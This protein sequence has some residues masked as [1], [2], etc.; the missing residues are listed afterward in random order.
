MQELI[1]F[2]VDHGKAV[3]FA[4]AFCEQL[5]L[6]VP[7]T[8]FFVGAGVMAGNG[9]GS[10]VGSYVLS[11]A[12]S[13]AGDC[14]WFFLGRYKGRD[15]LKWVCK[16]SLEP[17][18]CVRDTEERFAAHRHSSLIWARFLPIAGIAVRPLA[19]ITGMSLIRFLFFDGIGNVLYIAAAIGAGYFFSDDVERY[20]RALS[21]Y[22]GRLMEVA[23]IAL[24]LYLVY[25][26]I[27]RQLFLKR[28]GILRITPE[29]VRAQMA[30][31]QRPPLIDLRT[32]LL[33]QMF[34]F[35]I[36]GSLRIP[37]AELESRFDELPNNP[38]V[39]LYYDCPNEVTSARIALFLQ[40][41]GF[42]HA[43]PLQGGISLWKERELPLE[44][45]VS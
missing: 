22:R 24:G 13:L 31:E 44:A 12:G 8:L 14:V 15:V 20:V 2:L 34:P 45:V 9:Q 5:G 27:R 6:P 4:A 35:S 10:L 33:I 23:F 38:Y 42:H 30:T 28:L 39:V 21:P 16:F 26:L 17:D 25:K 36:Q 19:A 18:S 7:A 32:P 43:R 37:V 41:R 29:E 1:T 11:L 40:K 3:L